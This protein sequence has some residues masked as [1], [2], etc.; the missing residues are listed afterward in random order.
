MSWF[1]RQMRTYSKG[2]VSA[3]FMYDADGLRSAKGVNGVK[4]TYQYVGDKLYYEKI[5]NDKTLY[6]FYDSY[7]KLATIY[8][9]FNNGTSTSRA[10][11][12][13]LT[14][15][16]GDVVA[17]YNHTG[18]LV[19]RY[20]Y[21]AWGNILSVTDA[22]GN[23][24]TQQNHIANANPI[25]YRGYYYD[26]DLGLYYLQ[27]RYY[28]SETGRFINA[29][30]TLNGNGDILG[31][32]MFIYC[33]NNPV[34]FSDSSGR[35]FFSKLIERA[36]MNLKYS[37]SQWLA[38]IKAIS[39]SFGYGIGLGIGFNGTVSGVEWGVEIKDT[40][41]TSVEIVGGKCRGKFSCGENYSVSFGEL[42]ET[43]GFDGYS[44][45]YDDEN[46]NCGGINGNFEKRNKC[47]ANTYSIENS[48]VLGVSS[49]LYIGVGGEI[50]FGLDLNAWLEEKHK[51]DK[52]FKE[53][54]E[55]WSWD[56]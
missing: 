51:L 46:C 31:F 23:A 22:N 3:N 13:T 7:G 49:S 45:Y 48:Q 34:M 41:T 40:E 24:I 30:G 44:H 15:A 25:R 43:G 42:F 54:N 9:G 17:I 55:S 47:P 16:Q 2:S 8:Y 33:S 52:E 6:Y 4:T 29:D 18:A 1:G 56:D 26:A 32:N 39:I 53:F 10:I 28:D 5:G 35:G 11:Y 38:P 27:S 21:D 19:A 36:K 50:S 14:N 37:V 12:H 20:E